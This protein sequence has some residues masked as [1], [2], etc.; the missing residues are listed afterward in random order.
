LPVAFARWLKTMPT[1]N[2]IHFYINDRKPRAKAVSDALTELAAK[3][4]V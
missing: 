1:V 2:S 4:S 3:L